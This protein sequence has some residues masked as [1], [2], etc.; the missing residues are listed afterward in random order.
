MS[1]KF[2]KLLTSLFVALVATLSFS[3][4]AAYADSPHYVKGPTATVSGNSLVVA[5]KAA[6]LGNA[7]YADFTLTG[8]VTATAQCFTKSGN[9]VNGVPKSDTTSVNASGTFPVRNG[10]VTGSFTVSPLT[11][12]KCTGNQQVRI[13]SVSYDLYLNGAGL[14]QV[15][16]VS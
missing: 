3:A 12:L 9:P 14:P 13:L 7:Q 15:H 1:K 11:T 8:T 6:G 2:I 5:W 10:Q 16:L 4:T